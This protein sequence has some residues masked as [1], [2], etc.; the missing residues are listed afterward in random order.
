MRFLA[1]EN[2]PRLIV[3]ALQTMGHDI[4][5]VRTAA[6]GTADRDVLA[7][8]V[9]DQRVLLALD[10]DFGDSAARSPIG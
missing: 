5:W 2:V 6:P 8:A 3:A 7:W 9:R 1:N 4:A 10:K